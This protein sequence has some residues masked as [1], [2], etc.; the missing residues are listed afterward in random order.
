MSMD[1]VRLQEEIETQVAKYNELHKKA[2]QLIQARNT[3]YEQES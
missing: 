3:L 1:I 2:Q